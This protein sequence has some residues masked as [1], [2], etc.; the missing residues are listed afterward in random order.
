MGF[1]LLIEV[2]CVHCKF[3]KTKLEG[4]PY[5]HLGRYMCA[6]V[7]VCIH[8]YIYIYAPARLSKCCSYR[9]G[10]K[11]VEKPFYNSEP[12]R[13]VDVRSATTTTESKQA[14]SYTIHQ[15]SLFSL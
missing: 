10:S 8:M 5:T 7:F 1:V 13:E 14:S 3:F 2:D 4:H 15:I 9:I 12:F 11:T 6:G